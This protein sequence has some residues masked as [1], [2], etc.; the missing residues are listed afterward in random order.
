[1]DGRTDGR[2]DGWTD[3]GMDG[4][5]RANMEWFTM[6]IPWAL[7]FHG[8]WPIQLLQHSQSHLL[9][10]AVYAAQALGT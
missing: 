10:I 1:M 4:Y 2:I 5:A 8:G 6:G 3:G 9:F 7:R